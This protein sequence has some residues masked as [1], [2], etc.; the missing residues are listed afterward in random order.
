M[1]IPAVEAWVWSSKAAAARWDLVLGCWPITH[2]KA[3]LSAQ[4]GEAVTF[5]P[6]R[7]GSMLPMSDVRQ[8]LSSHVEV[9][10]PGVCLQPG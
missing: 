10:G 2:E 6:S 5:Y 9:R 1:R 7:C 8:N 3:A 4:G